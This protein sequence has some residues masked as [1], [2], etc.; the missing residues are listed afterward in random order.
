VV[1]LLVGVG[2]AGALTALALAA[3]PSVA[4]RASKPHPD[5]ADGLSIPAA[6]PEAVYAG[7]SGQIVETPCWSYEG[8]AL[9]VNSVSPDASALCYG[10]QEL[11]GEMHDGVVVPAGDGEVYGQVSVEP[12]RVEA[13]ESWAPGTDVDAVVDALA[14]SYFPENGTILSLHEGATLDGVPANVTRVQGTS[15]ATQTKAF[16][17]AFA[18][19]TYAPGPDEVR[20]FVIAIVTPYSNGDELID[21]VLDSWRWV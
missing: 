4:T 14:V 16:I 12:V 21:Q 8:P 9:F 2:G 17:T 13:S 10:A 11:W 6:D 19:R 7:V 3:D 15:G 5:A 1:A 18:P 20:L